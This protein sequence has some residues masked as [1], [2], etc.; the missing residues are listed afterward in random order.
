MITLDIKD[1]YIN[2]TVKGILRR[3]KTWLQKTDNNQEINK[4]IIMILSN[5]MGQNYFQYIKQCYKRQ[6]EIAMCSPISGFL[7]EIYIQVMEEKHKTQDR[8]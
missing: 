4:Q 8:K 2:L 5:I 1:I 6:N 7:A 3:A